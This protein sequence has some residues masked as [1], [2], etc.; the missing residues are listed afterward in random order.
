MAVGGCEIEFNAPIAMRDGVTLRA[1]VWRP[2][3]PGPYAAI[4]FRTPYDKRAVANIECVR[5]EDLVR[6]GFAVVVQDTRGRFAS[7]GEWGGIMWS[8][9]GRDGFDTIAWIAAQPW[10][11][12]AVGMAGQSYLAIV[13]LYAALEKPPALKAIAPTMAGLAPFDRIETGGAFRLDQLFGWLIFMGAEWLQKRLQAGAPISD[14]EMRLITEALAAPTRVMAHRPLREA[15]HLSLAGFPVTAADLFDGAAA[16]APSDVDLEQIAIPVLQVAGWYD[17]FLR[18]AFGVFQALDADERRARD[19]NQLLVG[20]WA[21]SGYLGSC[22]GEVNFGAMASGRGAGVAQ[23]HIDFFRR[24][25]RAEKGE[26]PKVRYFVMRAN[27]WRTSEAWPPSSMHQVELFLEPEAVSD[28]GASA[29]GLVLDGPTAE[30]PARTYVYDPADPT[31][32]RGG[33]VLNL[34]GLAFGP[35]DQSPLHVRSDI[36]WYTSEP[37]ADSVTLVGPVRL[38]LFVSSTAADTDFIARLCDVDPSGVSIP[39]TEGML[40]ARYRRGFTVE[41]L[42]SAGEVAELQIELGDTAWR[43]AQGHRLRLYVASA[44]YP[45]IDPNMNTGGPVGS[46]ATGRRAENSIHHGSRNPSRLVVSMAEQRMVFAGQAL[47]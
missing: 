17:V 23:A 25:L 37:L 45:H 10:C 28:G 14:G 18:T 3:G 21:H 42:L 47:V 34:A 24:H 30:R 32:T 2:Q 22:Y 5:P 26:A 36:I 19:G 8:Q 27:E 9:E 16:A 13:Q 29:G 7:E 4:L 35:L 38:Q 43:L 15:P 46:D 31:P 39:I 6:A 33:R 44:N 41:H 12:G 40:R 20:P 11:S 1:D